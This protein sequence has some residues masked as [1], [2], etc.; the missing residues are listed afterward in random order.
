M[1]IQ[2]TEAMIRAGAEKESLARGRE[3][4]REG[5]VYDTA[6]SGDTLT[7]KCRGASAPY[8]KLRVEFDG[9]GIHNASCTCAYE[10]GGYC[11]HIVSVLLA[12]MNDPAS[13]EPHTAP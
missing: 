6:V 4:Y 7:A 11:K 12:Y 13:F 3:Y 8:Y 9:A 1:P 5:A 2:L 10:Y